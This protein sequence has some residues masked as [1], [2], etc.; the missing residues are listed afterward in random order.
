MKDRFFFG[1]VIKT[2]AIVGGFKNVTLIYVYKK[3]AKSKDKI[4]ELSLKD[5]LVPPMGTNA[6]PWRKGFFETL[7]NAPVKSSDMLKSH[8][9]RNVLR[10]RLINDTGQVVTGEF[11]LVG[12]DGLHSYQTID[13]ELSEALGLPVKEE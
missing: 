6:L 7:A 3:S 13:D 4:P 1:R 10:K 12:S 9:F 5:L 2:D 11:D 8:V